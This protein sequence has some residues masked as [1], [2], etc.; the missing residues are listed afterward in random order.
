MSLKSFTS[1]ENSNYPIKNPTNFE[2]SKV[3]IEFSV[4]FQ[5]F[6]SDRELKKGL[7]TIDFENMKLVVGVGPYA[8][9]SFL[10]SETTQEMYVC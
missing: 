7:H 8:L 1:S 3:F 4:Q 6:P 9:Y 2:R 10:A 5:I